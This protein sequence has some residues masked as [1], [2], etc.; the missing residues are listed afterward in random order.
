[1]AGEQESKSGE[2]D[3]RT[4]ENKRIGR[5]RIDKLHEYFQALLPGKSNAYRKYYEKQW[6]IDEFAKGEEHTHEHDEK[7]YWVNP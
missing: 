6:N 5:K 4:R 3:I 1:M 7:R 2:V